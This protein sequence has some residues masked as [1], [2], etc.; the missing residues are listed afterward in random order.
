MSFARIV[1]KLTVSPLLIPALSTVT[2]IRGTL[3]APVP[4]SLSRAIPAAVKLKFGVF[5]SFVVMVMFSLKYPSVVGA[6][7]A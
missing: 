1:P 2:I 6:K 7:A 3:T 4:L 5:G